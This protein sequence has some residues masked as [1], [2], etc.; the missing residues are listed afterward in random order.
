MYAEEEL[1]R[2]IVSEELFQKTL[3]RRPGSE[4][5]ISDD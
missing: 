3:F 1:F 2:K 4:R 5:R